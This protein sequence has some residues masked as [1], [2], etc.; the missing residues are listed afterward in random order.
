M[1]S[2]SEKKRA[3]ERTPGHSAGWTAPRISVIVCVYNEERYI[4][5]CLAGIFGQSV[6]DFELIVVD[7]GSCDRSPDIMGSFRDE[8]LQVHRHAANLGITK[9]KNTGLAH[10]AGEFIFFTDADCVPDRDWLKNSLGAFQDEHIGI[11]EGKILPM[12]EAYVRV[13]SDKIPVN[14]IGGRFSTG[15]IAYRKGFLDLAGRKIDVK[16]DGFEDREL[17]LRTSKLCDY[18]FC[19]E[20][21]V[22]HQSKKHTCK[23]FLDMARRIPAKIYLAKE[24]N[25]RA[26]IRF[27]IV[28]PHYLLCMLFPP[29]VLV[30][31]LR[32]QV[33]SLRDVPFVP[34]LYVYALLLRI[35]IWRT[36][37]R[38]R[39]FLL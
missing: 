15:N 37:L 23:S 29:L 24:Y 32:S 25:D 16:Y 28:R 39:I 30:P 35:L 18:A 22:R 2:I 27:R 10:A 31:I 1:D 17:G 26:E 11:V 36:S 34:L 8:R 5:D 13:L 3:A 14:A 21:V 7:D 33:R 19:P 20:S 12:A 9:S 38:A 6:S 4:G